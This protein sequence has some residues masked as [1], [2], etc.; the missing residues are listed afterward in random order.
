MH[1]KVWHASGRQ[2]FETCGTG[3]RSSCPVSFPDVLDRDE[4]HDWECGY[5][6]YD[7]SKERRDSKR[8]QENELDHYDAG[9]SDPAHG[10][11]LQK[12]LE[13]ACLFVLRS[14]QHVNCDSFVDEEG[15]RDA[16]Y[17]R[18]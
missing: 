13:S 17:E 14:F 7:R 1:G 11:K 6:P 10:L 5:R 12:S 4:I 18:E 3:D 8:R 15:S 16:D 9:V 2:G